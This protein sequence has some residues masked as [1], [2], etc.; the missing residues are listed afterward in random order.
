[1]KLHKMILAGSLVFLV[2]SFWALVATPSHAATYEVKMYN[3]DPNNKKN[4]RNDNFG[5]GETKKI[6]KCI[7]S[8]LLAKIKYKIATESAKHLF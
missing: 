6:E 5:L 4:R 8:I 3:K 2:S 1:M 7:K